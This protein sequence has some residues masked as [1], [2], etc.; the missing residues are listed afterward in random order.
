MPC[1][2][3]PEL[4]RLGPAALHR[5]GAT[6]VKPTARRRLNRVGHLAGEADAYYGTVIRKDKHQSPLLKDLLRLLKNLRG[7]AKR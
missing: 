1:P 6:R 2:D 4:R 7:V 5:L 3:L